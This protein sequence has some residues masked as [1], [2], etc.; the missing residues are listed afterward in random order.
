MIGTLC[1]NRF[2]ILIAT[3]KTTDPARSHGYGH[4]LL[5]N[6]IA[7]FHTRLKL[8][9]G[10]TDVGKGWLASQPWPAAVGRPCAAVRFLASDRTEMLFS[11]IELSARGSTLKARCLPPPPSQCP[12]P[13]PVVPCRPLSSP[14]VPW[15]LALLSIPAFLCVSLPRST[16]LVDWPIGR[17][18]SSSSAF[19][20]FSL[21]RWI[22]PAS[23]LFASAFRRKLEHPRQPA[24]CSW[25]CHAR[26]VQLVSAFY[27]SYTCTIYSSN[28]K[29]KNLDHVHRSVYSNAYGESFQRWNGHGRWD[30]FL[31][32]INGDTSSISL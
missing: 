5:A 1:S 21:L 18:S 26:S 29:L 28:E 16:T 31:R 32:S 6:T 2:S 4:A 8:V 7:R 20:S 13:S 30:R 25:L 24:R 17:S 19:L 10:Q 12:L 11:L 9:W 3:W 22:L 23:C 15:L 14:V 27:A